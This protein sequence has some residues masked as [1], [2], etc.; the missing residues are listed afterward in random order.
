MHPF[1]SSVLVASN[2]P[3][4]SYIGI[5]D[6]EPDEEPGEESDE[7]RT[8]HR[9]TYDPTEKTWTFAFHEACWQVLLRQVTSLSAL[10]HKPQ[11]IGENLFKLLYC[12]PR[13]D[14]GRFVR[15]HNFGD[16]IKL[17]HPPPTLWELRYR[18]DPGQFPWY[19]RSIQAEPK[20]HGIHPGLPSP[21]SPSSPSSLCLPFPLHRSSDRFSRMP[22]EVNFMVFEL[23]D[24]SDFCNLRLGSKAVANIT[25]P[26]FLPMSFWASRFWADKEMAFASFTYDPISCFSQ[27]NWKELYFQL[28]QALSD[29][30]EGGH[31]RNLSRIW[32]CIR[33]PAR[34][35]V[36]MLT[37]LP[38]LGETKSSFL[39]HQTVKR[40]SQFQ[41]HL[42]HRFQSK[43]DG[44]G[45]RVLGTSQVLFSPQ[46]SQATFLE[47]R[48]SFLT[49]YGVVFICGLRVL[50]GDE[51]SSMTD[52]SRSGII[53]PQTEV[54]L[55]VSRHQYLDSIVVASSISGIVGLG[56]RISDN[57]GKSLLK[58]AGMMSD[59]PDGTGLATLEP[60]R[61]F[62]L[63][64]AVVGLDVSSTL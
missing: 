47:I 25:R 23:L 63:C 46:G 33:H 26:S 53:V 49:F 55:S 11:E 8:A 14:K 52:I 40:G 3:T 16:A 9:L 12:L 50:A 7:E 24:S 17:W 45:V 38:G 60:E 6:E 54:S 48:V 41:G 32:T 39:G 43:S 19:E 56:F 18:S 10:P 27:I 51:M 1:H 5:G 61:G 42:C 28:R 2:D 58:T 36:P 30:S 29:T 31:V 22:N 57:S 35:L 37:Q 62:R 4:V 15:H 34:S 20:M 13:D 64:G 44:L 21:S 59:L